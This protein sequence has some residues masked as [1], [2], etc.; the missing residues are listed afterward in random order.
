MSG[1]KPHRE[2]GGWGDE[3]EGGVDGGRDRQ[4]ETDRER[5]KKAETETQKEKHREKET[6]TERERETDRFSQLDRPP[7]RTEIRVQFN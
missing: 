6:E 1:N 5:H 4:T 2:T 3:G 7:N